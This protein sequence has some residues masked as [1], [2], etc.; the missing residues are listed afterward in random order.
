MKG[1]QNK[2][3]ES[4]KIYGSQ[5][6]EIERERKMKRVK[7]YICCRKRKG[8][9]SWKQKLMFVWLFFLPFCAA[10]S[11]NPSFFFC[12][13]FFL[14]IL[15][16]F[17]CLLS[18]FPLFFW[19]CTLNINKDCSLTLILFAAIRFTATAEM[20]KN[21]LIFENDLATDSTERLLTVAGW[22]CSSS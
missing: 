2:S 12:C 14:M 17:S 9:K 15:L 19:Q 4:G 20:L 5:G 8:R 18:L 1:K 16:W 7:N 6:R 21:S 10:H 13:C 3:E 11:M 22:L